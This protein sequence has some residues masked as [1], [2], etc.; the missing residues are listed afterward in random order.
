MLWLG[1]CGAGRGMQHGIW[2]Y[3]RRASDGRAALLGLLALLEL[4]AVACRKMP[5]RE[6]VKQLLLACESRICSAHRRA[7]QRR[8]QIELRHEEPNRVH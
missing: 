6:P 2:D 4:L 7:A 1:R 5:P 3:I 8:Q